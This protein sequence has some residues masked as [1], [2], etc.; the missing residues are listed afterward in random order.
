MLQK[1]EKEENCPRI[2]RIDTDLRIKRIKESALSSIR[3]HPCD[4]WANSSQFLEL[5]NISFVKRT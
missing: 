5:R 2:T 1:A 3:V 4:L